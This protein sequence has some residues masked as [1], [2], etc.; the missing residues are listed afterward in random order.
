MKRRRCGY[1]GG[2]LAL[3]ALSW[4]GVVVA[5]PIYFRHI[6][7]ARAPLIE[8]ARVIRDDSAGRPCAVVALVI[9]QLHWYSHC[10]G[11]ASQLLAPLP[12]DHLRYAASFTQW[13]LDLPAILAAQHLLATPLPIGDPHAMLW[14]LRDVTP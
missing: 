12:A 1:F 14:R 13:P 5:A 9:P 2:W 10:E 8:A 7:A 6:D 3:V 4:L 11:Y